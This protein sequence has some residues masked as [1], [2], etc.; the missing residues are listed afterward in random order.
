MPTAYEISGDTDGDGLEDW[1]EEY[2]FGNLDQGPDDDPDGDGIV[3]SDE[4]AAGTEPYLA[5]V[6]ITKDNSSGFSVSI[7]WNAVVGR[8]YSVEFSDSVFG[9][10]M[11][12]TAVQDHFTVVSS[13]VNEWVDD[14]TLTGVSPEDVPYRYYKI[15][16]Y[17]PGVGEE[18]YAVDTVGLYWV[19]VLQGRNLVS[20]PFEPHIEPLDDNA[21]LDTLIGDALTGSPIKVFSDTIESWDGNNYDRA[22]Y[23]D[24]SVTKEWR[25]WET[26]TAPPP[27]EFEADKGYWVNVLVFNPPAEICLLGK[28]STGDRSIGLV[29]GRNLCGSAF[30]KSVS[31]D[32]SGLIASG[33][34]GGVVNFFSD[35]IE[36]WNP[37]TGNYDR[38]WYDTS[39]SQWKNWD[40]TPATRSFVPTEGFW[41]NILAFNPPFT[42]TCP[43]PYSQP[44]ND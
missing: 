6:D 41:V 32:D 38:V 16:V 10:S 8:E 37:V 40:D 13:G 17:G 14:G 28:V 12:W 29:V 2:Y 44:P 5:I 15:K 42:W 7:H 30:P 21:E 18:T 26:E 25:D 43:K 1:W 39:V 11:L 33:F 3:N 31:L 35:N 22:Y 19:S 20:T 27:F 34:T 24:D 4:Q 23:Y 36:W 9:D